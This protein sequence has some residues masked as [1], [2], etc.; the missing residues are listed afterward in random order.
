MLKVLNKTIKKIDTFQEDCASLIYGLRNLLGESTSVADISVNPTAF[1]KKKRLKESIVK[2]STGDVV[3]IDEMGKK[4]K[5][6]TAVAS[7]IDKG[8][9]LLSAGDDGEKEEPAT[10]GDDKKNKTDDTSKKGSLRGKI[11]KTEKEL[12]S[13]KSLRKW[14]I[15][16]FEARRQG[17]FGTAEV[18]KSRIDQFISEKDLDEPTIYYRADAIEQAALEKDEK[19]SK[20]DDEESDEDEDKE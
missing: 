1:E 14:V 12:E 2:T 17:N 4:K 20:S 19:D 16:Y 15:Q 10:D 6:P 13:N 7:E 9:K 3:E 11:V 8:G 5:L 18:L